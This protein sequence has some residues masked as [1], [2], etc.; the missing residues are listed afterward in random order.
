VNRTATRTVRVGPLGGAVLGAAVGLVT[1]ALAV[2]AVDRTGCRPATVTGPERSPATV[3]TSRMPVA[4]T[5]QAPPTL[6]V[7]P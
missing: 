1:L 4:A 6:P 7:T 3:P 2:G 5:P